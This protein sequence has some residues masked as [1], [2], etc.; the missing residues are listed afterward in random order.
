[1]SDEASA[2]SLAQTILEANDLKLEAVATP[3]WPAVD[4]SVYVRCM[5]VRDL[6]SYQIWL[7]RRTHE[8]PEGEEGGVR[9]QVDDADTVQIR[10]KILVRSV[11]DADGKLLFSEAD[12]G[13][14]GKKNAI[15]MDRLYQAARRINDLDVAKNENPPKSDG[16]NSSTPL[17]SPSE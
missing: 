6:D 15:T 12:M 2:P 16:E 3:E 4:G 9:L 14:L 11:C 10:E 7:M 1:M 13:A 8:V 5:E 17:P